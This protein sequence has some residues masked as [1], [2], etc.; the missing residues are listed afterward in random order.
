MQ[1]VLSERY[2]VALEGTSEG[3]FFLDRAADLPLFFLSSKPSLNFDD[4]KILHSHASEP[5]P[6][7]LALI[8]ILSLDLAFFAQ[9][10]MV[11]SRV[12][13]RSGHAQHRDVVVI[14]TS[15]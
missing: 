2:A 12:T 13:R 6:L 10:L 1:I 15:L 9:G 8:L 3:S 4:L 5:I 14:T 7:S 11:I